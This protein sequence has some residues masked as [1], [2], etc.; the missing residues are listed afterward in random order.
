MRVKDGS[1]ES[2]LDS[3]SDQR[4]NPKPGGV[5]GS[6][7]KSGNGPVT[8][9][10]HLISRFRMGV[11]DTPS[12]TLSL[13]SRL[14]V[15][16]NPLLRSHPHATLHWS[17]MIVCPREMQ[18]GNSQFGSICHQSHGELHRSSYRRRDCLAVY[19]KFGETGLYKRLLLYE[20]VCKA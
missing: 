13:I 10:N 11:Y 17:S 15:Q 1:R 6:T 12:S 16:N 18:G 2:I 8:I 4:E 5:V 9:V 7:Q 19:P 20:L 3:Q 14:I